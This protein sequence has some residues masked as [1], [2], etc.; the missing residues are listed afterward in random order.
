LCADKNLLNHALVKSQLGALGMQVDCVSKSSQVLECMRRAHGDGR[1]YSLGMIDGHLNGL[2]GTSLARRIK[3]DTTLSG[4]GL[5]L[6]GAFDQRF[7]EETFLQAG[8][9]SFLVKP[10]RRSQLYDCIVAA[11]GLTAASS[12]PTLTDS[13]RTPEISSRISIRVLVVEDN[14]INQKVAVRMLEKLGCR[15]D[16]AANGAKALDALAGYTYDLV[17]MDCQMPEMDGFTAT[18]AI[19][20]RERQT[21]RHL[22]I[23][24]MTANAIRGDRE[25]CLAAGM[26]DYIS[27]PVDFDSLSLVLQ[28]WGSCPPSADC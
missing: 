2:D 8:F 6:L 14:I 21:D 11:M 26:D 24:A 4:T 17:F 25:Q 28:R 20:E 23:I 16:V 10:I 7:Q 22:P 9:S 1:P 27:K 3:T 12:T 19:R 15:V 18:A 5:I 13:H